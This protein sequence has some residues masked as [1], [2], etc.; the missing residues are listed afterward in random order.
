MNNNCPKNDQNPFNIMKQPHRKYVQN[1]FFPFFEPTVHGQCST[2]CFITPPHC[3]S[4]F[5][6]DLV[7]LVGCTLRVGQLAN[8]GVAKSGTVSGPRCH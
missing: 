6:P 5:Q 2:S 4:R 7:G 3:S 8:I 1:M